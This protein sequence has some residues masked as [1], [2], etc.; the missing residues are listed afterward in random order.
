MISIGVCKKPHGVG[1]ELKVQIDAEYVA[2][3]L[4]SKVLFIGWQGKEVPYFIENI[5]AGHDIFVKLE[6]LDTREAAAVLAGK[7]IF[8]REEDL[9]FAPADPDEDDP[10]AWIGYQLWDVEH[11]LIGAIEDVVEYPQ[12]IMAVL[13]YQGREIL[14]PLN[15]H[16]IEAVDLD[17]Q[18]LRMNLPTGLL[19]L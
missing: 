17:A 4:E 5:R 12:Q 7:E 19:E 14:I 11:G 6:D 9:Q 1:G 16:L 3:F 18:T 13:T 10:E 2:G 8:L 15:E